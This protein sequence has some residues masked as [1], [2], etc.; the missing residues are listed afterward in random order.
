MNLTTDDY[1]HIHDVILDTLGLTPTNAQIDRLIP[2][3][4]LSIIGLAE[5]WGWSD[6]EAR[7]NLA[8]WLRV[9]ESKAQRVMTLVQINHE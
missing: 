5:Q 1:N 7:E 4:P 8:Q 3:L 2:V 6:T 9:Y